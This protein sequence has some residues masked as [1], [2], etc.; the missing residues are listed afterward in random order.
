MNVEPVETRKHGKVAGL[1]LVACMFIGLGVGIIFN[2]MPAALFIGMGVGFL[3]MAVWKY[4]N[5]E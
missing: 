4:K 2:W 3:I 1:F 5:N